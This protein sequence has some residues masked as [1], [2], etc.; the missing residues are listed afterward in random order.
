VST[1]TLPFSFL[2]ADSAMSAVERNDLSVKLC[3]VAE[4]VV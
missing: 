4:T 2:S 1:R 3:I